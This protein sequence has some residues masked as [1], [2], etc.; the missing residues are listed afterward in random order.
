LLERA[1]GPRVALEGRFLAPLGPRGILA[2]MLR[3]LKV[4]LLS[5]NDVAR[6]G[7]ALDAM[8]L[9][10]PTSWMDRRD[11]G[12]LRHGQG[13]LLGASEDFEAYLLHQGQAEDADDICSLLQ[14]V[15]RRQALVN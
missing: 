11:R 9:L 10:E 4:I 14:Q 8:L 6:A 3:N 1:L 15:R 5:R 7:T 13:D 2:R 12:K